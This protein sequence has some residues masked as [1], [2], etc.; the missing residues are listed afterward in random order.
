M[1]KPQAVSRVADTAC[2][3]AMIQ[4]LFSSIAQWQSMPTRSSV[5]VS[6]IHNLRSEIQEYGNLGAQTWTPYSL[7]ICTVKT[8]QLF[9][10]CL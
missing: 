9:L 10:C 1:F 3:I 8:E 7:T 6:I 4:L 5:T 2:S